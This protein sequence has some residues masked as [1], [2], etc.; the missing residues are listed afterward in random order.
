MNIACKECGRVSE[1]TYTNGKPFP[2]PGCKEPLRFS[3]GTKPD[4][5]DTC[6][7]KGWTDDPDEVFDAVTN[8][9]VLGKIV[10][11]PSPYLGK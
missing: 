9:P 4:L 1:P 6:M 10:S 2:V 7:S 8:D 11:K 5:C 3:A